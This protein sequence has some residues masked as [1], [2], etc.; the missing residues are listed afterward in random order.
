MP[1]QRYTAP[2]RALHWIMAVLILPTIPAGL[3]MVQPGIDRSLQN[4]LFLYHKNVG[5]LLLLLVVLRIVWRLR[6]PAPP[7]PAQMPAWQVRIAHLTHVVL[8]ALLVILPVAGYIRVRAG[9]FPIETLD[10]LGLPRLVP[11]SDALAETAKSVHYVAGLAIAAVLAMHV[12][13]ALMHGIV[14]RDGVFS[15]MWPPFGRARG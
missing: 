4:A 8:Y 2:A 10:A 11:R 6:N 14:R 12:G 5:V 15:R 7:L 9:G 3:V 1:T 13:A